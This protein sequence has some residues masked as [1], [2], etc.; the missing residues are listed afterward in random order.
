MLRYS[1]QRFAFHLIPTPRPSHVSSSAPH[2][3]WD[4]FGTLALVNKSNDID[5]A[6]IV[7]VRPPGIVDYGVMKEFARDCRVGPEGWYHVDGSF[8]V[9]EI[10]Q[11]NLLQA[12]VRRIPLLFKIG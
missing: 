9:G 6:L 7:E 12:Q 8:C 2:S 10:G 4:G 1:S 11:A 5:R 3:L